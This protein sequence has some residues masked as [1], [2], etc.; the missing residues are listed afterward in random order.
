[1]LRSPSLLLA[2]LALLAPA[3]LM[4][5]PASPLIPTLSLHVIN[6]GATTTASGRVFIP[7]QRTTP[8]EGMEVAEV[9]GG[10]PWPFPDAA[11]NS[12][13][14][15]Q[16]GD[17]AFVG[18]NSIRIGPDGDLWVVD[19]GADGNGGA[20]SSLQPKILRI[21]VT[22]GQIK[23]IYPLRSVTTGK[24]FVNDLRFKGNVA[25][26]TDAGQ[27][28][29]I[30]LHLDTG[31]A[32]R[33]LDGDPSTTAQRPWLSAGKPLVTPEGK[34]VV[35]HADQ[36][37]LSPDAAWLYYQPA[38]GPMS[39]IET[40]YLEDETLS[41]AQLAAHVI[42]FA[43]TQP[44]GGTAIASN[45]TIFASD[46]NHQRLVKIAPNGKITTILQDA[47]L[48][49]MD[50]MWIDDQ[51]YLWIPATQINRTAGLNHGVD[52]VQWPVIT[53][54]MQTGLKPVHR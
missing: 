24:S 35:V 16:K 25:F 38:S 50:A 45:G 34:Q 6:N 31:A 28:G 9:V 52:A 18:V 20:D 27:P 26:L 37:E 10:Q 12:W 23:R 48:I 21:D 4:A 8:G 15:G 33:V 42:P 43:G 54:R 17:A 14:P 29:L 13:K 3:G 51:G 22:S 32:R 36:L 41:P 5:A 53:Y 30:V 46:I 44:T 47:R 2:G 49:Q 1:M 19:K 40:R 39:K 7:V 11:W